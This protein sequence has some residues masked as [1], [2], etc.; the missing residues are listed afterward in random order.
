ML[1]D[2]GA[3][4]AG[5]RQF[6]FF[7]GLEQAEDMDVQHHFEFKALLSLCLPSG[8]DLILGS[9]QD[10]IPRFMGKLKL[11]PDDQW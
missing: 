5:P 2:L 10:H 7:F 8:P 1:H 11:N 6:R 4:Q 9:I 3:E